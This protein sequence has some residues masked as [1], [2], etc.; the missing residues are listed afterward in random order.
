MLKKLERQIPMPS[1]FCR[2]PKSWPNKKSPD[3]MIGASSYSEKS[4]DYFDFFSS[5]SI[6]SFN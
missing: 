1:V 6:C 2:V 4:S 5:P 3:Q